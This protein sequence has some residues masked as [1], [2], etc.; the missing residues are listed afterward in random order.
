[1]A[2]RGTDIK[3]SDYVTDLGGLYVIGT[4]RRL[5]RQL[6][7]RCACQADPRL[8]AFF[9]SLE[10]DLVR[11]L[12]RNGRVAAMLEKLGHVEGEP[13][14]H[15]VLTRSLSSAQTRVENARP[16]TSV[17]SKPRWG[18]HT[19]H[20]DLLITSSYCRVLYSWLIVGSNLGPS[21]S[22]GVNR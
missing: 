20:I 4:E 10:D 2:G 13:L 14:D 22:H 9:L 5:D 6:V 21:R 16:T 17:V 1:M 12:D 19:F 3:L 18:L 11:R 8:S 7:G 15:P